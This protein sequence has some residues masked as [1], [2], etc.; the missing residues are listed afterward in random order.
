LEQLGLARFL[1]SAVAAQVEMVM[2]IQIMAAVAAQADM[3]IALRNTYQQA[4]L[5]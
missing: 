3:F 4:R 1:L 5:L 2:A